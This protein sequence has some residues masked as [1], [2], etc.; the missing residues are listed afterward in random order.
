MT[1]EVLDQDSQSTLSIAESILPDLEFRE[2]QGN[3][4]KHKFLVLRFVGFS[5]REALAR[6][7]MHER[8][9]RRWRR[10][11]TEFCALEGKVGTIDGR[12]ARKEILAQKFSRNLF[13]FLERDYRILVKAV[14]RERDE[15]GEI[16]WPTRDEL[17]YLSKARTSYSPQQLE[18]LEGALSSKEG[19]FD[20]SK[21]I[22]TMSRKT[23]EVRL[24]SA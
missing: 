2:G 24:E 19:G 4:E 5:I 21:F 13:M 10:D 6:V 18:A 16:T 20:I 17:T 22:L 23:E 1:I 3:R 9:L 15:D 7:N 14:G 8:T 12:T 11:D